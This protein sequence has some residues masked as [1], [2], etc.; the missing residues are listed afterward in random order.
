MS[1]GGGRGTI[2]VIA[3]ADC[4]NVC[5]CWR[6]DVDI[7]ALSLAGWSRNV[8]VRGGNIDVIT[9]S[10]GDAGDRGTID[11][12]AVS[13][14]DREKVCRSRRDGVYEWCA[15]PRSDSAATGKCG[16]RRRARTEPDG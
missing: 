2:D 12:T 1:I 7:S 16:S 10:T 15:N 13:G 11:V 3:L 6:D 8:G 5:S 14:G 4:E 9:S